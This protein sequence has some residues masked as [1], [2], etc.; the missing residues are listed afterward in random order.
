MCGIAGIV[1]RT[2]SKE[3]GLNNVKNMLETI[4]QRGPDSDGLWSDQIVFLGH[5]RLSIHD[6]SP[7]GHQPM[8]S[9]SGRYTLVFNGEIYNFHELKKELQGISWKGTSD[10][11]VILAAFDNWG[12]EKS[13]EKLNGMFA[14]AVWDSQK[15]QLILAR[16]RFGEKP[17]Y[18][19]NDGQ[20]FIFASEITCF[21]ALDHLPLSLNHSAILQQMQRSYIPNPLSIYNGVN[22][23]PP[24]EYLT[25]SSNGKTEIKSYWTLS[26][27]IEKSLSSPFNDPDEAI[28]ELDQELRKAIKIRMS[29]DVPL[30]AFLSGGVDSSLVCA[31]MQQQSE[32]PV[33]TFTIGFDVEGYNEAEQAKEVAQHLG[34][35]HTEFYFKPQDLLDIVPNI[36]SVFDEPFSD[37]SQI[38]TFLVSQIAKEKV[39][40]CLSGDGGDELFSGYKRYPGSIEM[41]NKIS[42]IPMRTL[43]ASLIQKTPTKLLDTSFKFLEGQTSKYGRQGKVGNK[44]KNFSNWM[45]AKSLLEFYSKTMQHWGEEIMAHPTPQ[46]HIWNPQSPDL[47][48]DIEKMM[49]MDSLNYLP[50]DI[51]T[52]VDRTAMTHSLEGRIP[53]LDPNVVA[54]AWRMPLEF[55]QRGNVGKWALKQVLYK[56][57]PQELMEKPKMGFGIPIH[58]WLTNELKEWTYDLLSQETLKRQGI[59][60]HQLVYQ[61]LENHRLGNENNSTLLWDVLMFQSWLNAKPKRTTL[62]G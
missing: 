24:G 29:S 7:T 45:D 53:L 4:H 8:L 46:A 32:R 39:T 25:L 27:C 56:Y 1:D 62:I 43:V 40:V 20:K 55:K 6:L 2:L 16:D 3:S 23:L 33:N 36:G 49:Y 9:H 28:N 37:A 19:Y 59:F 52:K 14:I 22:K 26:E 58:L 60:N 48:T 15:G 11:E 57:L 5:K 61:K 31:L 50:G 13:L 18:Y 34:T 17:L 41:W 21:E 51:L 38:P 30:G 10:T 35:N 42:K 54:T 47:P 12:V 44:L